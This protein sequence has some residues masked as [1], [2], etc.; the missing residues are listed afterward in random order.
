MAIVD[1]QETDFF[2]IK[3]YTIQRHK[4]NSMKRWSK[5]RGRK[6]NFKGEKNKRR[7]SSTKAYLDPGYHQGI[8]RGSFLLLSSLN[9]PL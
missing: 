6:W 4:C 7:T 2:E 3:E 9:H 8:F 1:P 5:R